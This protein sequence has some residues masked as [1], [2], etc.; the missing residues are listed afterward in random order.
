MGGTG[1]NVTLVIPERHLKENAC[2]YLIVSFKKK[3]CENMD[4]RVFMYTL[5]N[6]RQ[7]IEFPMIK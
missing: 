4:L 3:V 5:L 7:N 6:L 2:C 1:P